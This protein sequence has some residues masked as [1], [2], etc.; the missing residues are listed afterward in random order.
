MNKPR[1]DTDRLVN[2]W[3]AGVSLNDIAAHF[4]VQYPAINRIAKAIG[5]TPRRRGVQREKALQK[6]GLA[7]ATTKLGATGAFDDDS[8]DV[9][10]RLLDLR[11]QGLS[12]AQIAERVGV[13]KEAV[14]GLLFRVNRDADLADAAPPPAGQSRP[15]R[16]ENC[17][18]GMPARWWEPGLR[19]QTE[20][21]ASLRRQAMRGGGA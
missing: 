20:R 17:D 5:L 21:E 9:P 11:A 15:L 1:I 14:A 12:S 3:V 13:G 8:D 2:M 10:L 7:P 19:K 4:G 16:P 18:G 6:P